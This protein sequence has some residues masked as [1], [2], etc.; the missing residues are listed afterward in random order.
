[1]NEAKALKA[2]KVA[3]LAISEESLGHDETAEAQGATCGRIAHAAGLSLAELHDT[4]FT[5]TP[6]A[7]GIAWSAV[8]DGWFLARTEA[9]TAA[10]APVGALVER[11][12]AAGDQE[13]AALVLSLWEASL[14]A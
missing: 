7:S 4:A 1:M 11:L 5:G 8:V 9:R 10:F 14:Q 2:V 3:R 12:R 13:G 6:A